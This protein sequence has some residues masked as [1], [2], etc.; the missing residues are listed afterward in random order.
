MD[1][2]AHC[3]SPMWFFLKHKSQ[4]KRI[5]GYDK[6]DEM[7]QEIVKITNDTAWTNGNPDAESRE[8][9]INSIRRLPHVCFTQDQVRLPHE[10]DHEWIEVKEADV[11]IMG[12]LISLWKFSRQ[13]ASQGPRAPGMPPL[14]LTDE[15]LDTSISGAQ[16]PGH[17]FYANRPTL[18]SDMNLRRLFAIVTGVAYV[19][20]IRPES[21]LKHAQWLYDHVQ[22]GNYFASRYHHL[23]R[24]HSEPG[25]WS[26]DITLDEKEKTAHCVRLSLEDVI[27]NM[28]ERFRVAQT[29]K[30]IMG[31][32][33]VF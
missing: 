33:G 18:L 6:W 14:P 25:W 28:Q 12:R 21:L 4:I 9:A 29:A 23:L 20:T 24:E 1:F 7:E 5:F 19:S 10:N 16:W 27:H 26:V 3:T 8:S 2:Y 17:P 11:L 31:P 32:N 22:R 30:A 13:Q 15:M